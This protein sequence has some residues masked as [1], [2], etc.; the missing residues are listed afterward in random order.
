MA[1]VIHNINGR[2]YAYDH[3]RDGKSIR[4]TYIGP[5]D[6]ITEAEHIPRRGYPTNHPKY[7]EAHQHANKEEKKEYGEEKYE[8]LKES[9]DKKIPKGELAG[10]NTP[11]GRI[12]VHEKLNKDEKAQVAYHEMREYERMQNKKVELPI[13]NKEK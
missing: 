4:C 11:T 10:S 6:Y 8:A 13:K 12:I 3:W 2:N 9:I 7:R 5:A 1:I